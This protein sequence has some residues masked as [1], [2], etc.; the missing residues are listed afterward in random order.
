M[1]EPF[2]TLYQNMVLTPSS[3]KQFPADDKWHWNVN[4]SKTKDAFYIGDDNEHITILKHHPGFH[5]TVRTEGKLP[6]HLGAVTLKQIIQHIEYNT[7]D[8]STSPYQKDDI[9]KQLRYI[10][11]QF[12]IS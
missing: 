3:G 5:H 7:W 12:G 10:Q 4:L 11:E 2:D 1:A 9:L 6:Q 8:D